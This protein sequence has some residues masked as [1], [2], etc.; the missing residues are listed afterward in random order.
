MLLEARNAAWAHAAAPAGEK[1]RLASVARQRV[2]APAQ[3]P[4]GRVQGPSRTPAGKASCNINIS[5]TVSE[6]TRPTR[7]PLLSTTPM[8]DAD[9]SS[10]IR[11]GAARPGGV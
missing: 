11:D 9:F 8:A 10:N 2:I 4:V 1:L 6:V 3:A 7:R 5:P